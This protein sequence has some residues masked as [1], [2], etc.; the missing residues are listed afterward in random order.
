[1]QLFRENTVDEANPLTVNSQP[2]TGHSGNSSA[3]DQQTNHNRMAWVG[4]PTACVNELTGGRVAYG[5]AQPGA[6]GYRFFNRYYFINR[7][8][9]HHRR[10]GSTAASL[11]DVLDVL[12]RPL[13][14]Y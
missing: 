4:E 9:R 14:G 11:A 2:A 5:N 7:Q 3:R 8:S 10:N 12:N 1:V 13:L 6:E